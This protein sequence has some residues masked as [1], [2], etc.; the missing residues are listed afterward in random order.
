MKKVA[1]RLAAPPAGH[2]VRHSALDTHALAAL[3]IGQAVAEGA[4]RRLPQ[5]APRIAKL[6][7]RGGSRWIGPLIRS[8]L[9]ADLRFPF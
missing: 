9:T 7:R 1:E 8:R 3:H 6:P 5:L 4:T 2:R